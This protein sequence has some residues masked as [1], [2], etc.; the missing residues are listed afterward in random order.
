MTALPQYDRLEAQ[1][2]WRETPD[3]QRQEV[4]VS[5]GDATLVIADDRSARALA[6]WSLPAMVRRNPGKRPALYAPSIEEGEE[7]ELSDP[8]MI[9]AI[10]K[11][12][13]VLES[14]R[15]H[16]GRLRSVFSLGAGLAVAALV[17]F[18]L[19]GALIQQAARVAPEAKRAVIGR[20]VLAELATLTG[21][22]C[23]ATAGDEALTA[24]AERLGGPQTITVLPQALKGVRRLPG[25]IVVIGRDLLRLDTP[26][27][28]AGQIIAAELSSADQDPLLAL[29]RWSGARAA[30]KLLT[31]GDL[32]ASVLKGYGEVLLATPP[33]R[34]ADE[35]LLAAFE[36]AGISST[37][38]A[39]SIDPTGESVLG[40]IEADPFRDTP[41]P[42]PV[43]EDADWVALQNICGG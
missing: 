19:P 28:A 14:R 35:P 22:P 11:V 41:A 6:H 3:A 1:G 37:P 13:E 18:W 30:F 16:P 32:P 40:L 4:I 20:Q 5:F 27:P 21:R 23:H 24:L 38:Y 25:G 15:P 8:T 31:T 29:L 36:A 9:E 43:L 12:H 34:P 10:E 33:D 42:R 17:V 26:E 7:L 39:F 2:I